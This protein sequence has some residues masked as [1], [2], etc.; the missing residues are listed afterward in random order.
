MVRPGL[1]PRPTRGPCAR[2]AGGAV[3]RAARHRPQ[4]QGRR[5]GPRPS[6]PEPS[7][8]GLGPSPAGYPGFIPVGP[9]P[10]RC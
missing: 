4:A 1:D 6:R 5:R 7:G 10:R 8:R 2:P 9:R 3:G